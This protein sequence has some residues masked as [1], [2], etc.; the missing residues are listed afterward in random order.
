[1]GSSAMVEVSDVDHRYGDQRALEGVSLRAYRGEVLALIG[2]NGAGKTTLMALMSA[3]LRLQRGQIA[4]GEGLDRR[5]SIG[6]CPQEDELWDDLRCGEQMV[7]MARL[8]GLGPR[9]SEERCRQL[10]E[11]LG[12]AAVRERRADALSGGMRRRLSL[13]LALVHDPPVVILDEPEAGLDP[14]HRRRFRELIKGLARREGRAVIMATH[15]LERLEEL[16]DRVAILDEGHLVAHESCRS[17]IERV[18]A[19]SHL[20]AEVAVSHREALP[21]LEEKLE[22]LGEIQVRE[23]PGGAVVQGVTADPLALSEVVQ[24]WLSQG[25]RGLRSL[26]VEPPGLEEAYRR[27]LE[28]RR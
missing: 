21:E 16:A 27:L 13:A 7:M 20:N 5:Q 11:D 3:E 25:D 9:D 1:M 23:A 26:K 14:D 2:P 17:L 10:A 4:I 24:R 28:S 12:L 15:H 22:A 18:C 19:G 8:H 6:L